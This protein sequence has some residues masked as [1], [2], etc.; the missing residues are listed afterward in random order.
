MEALNQ[1][2][3][4]PDT[5]VLDQLLVAETLLHV[6]DSE[7]RLGEFVTQALGNVP[8]VV[9]CAMCIR[10]LSKLLSDVKGERC[11]S[12]EFRESSGD[13]CYYDCKLKDQDGIHV[14]DLKTSDRLYGFLILSVTSTERYAPYDPFISNFSGSI[15]INMEN[16][17]QKEGLEAA[18][19]HL[20]QEIEE[21]KQTKEALRESE[22]KYR[23]MM[24]SM[25]D[26]AY[27]C[28][29]DYRVEYLNPAMVKRTGRD[30]IGEVCGQAQKLEAIATLAGRGC[31]P[32]Q[33][34]LIFHHGT[35]RAA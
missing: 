8:G 31:P 26:P 30:A 11:L 4:D 24:E 6:F 10:G 16:R 28:S 9:L 35:R 33:Q 12:C 17:W 13:I 21:H 22:E 27:I 15:A 18:N 20:K 34:C 19:E 29:P 32:V 25:N 14:F 2:N 5:R 7:K 1:T 3:L 23:S